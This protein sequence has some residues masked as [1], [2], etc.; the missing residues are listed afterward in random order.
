MVV[1]ELDKNPHPILLSSHSGQ[2]DTLMKG[3]RWQHIRSSTTLPLNPQPTLTL[4]CQ[5]S[6]A[7]VLRFGLK[8]SL[9]QNFSILGWYEHRS[10][11]YIIGILTS[12][13]QTKTMWIAYFPPAGPTTHCLLRVYVVFFPGSEIKVNKNQ[14]SFSIIWYLNFGIYN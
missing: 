6:A 14:N 7:T 2:E 1:V 4:S 9:S 13:M 10:G 5:C 3:V 11:N 12:L 8:I